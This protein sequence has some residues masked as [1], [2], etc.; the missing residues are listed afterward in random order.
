MSISTPLPDTFP[1]PDKRFGNTQDDDAAVFES[2]TEDKAE[3]PL[4][5][6]LPLT[7]KSIP[8]VSPKIATR[9]MTA[10]IS[11]DHSWPPYL[12]LPKDTNRTTIQIWAAS[13]TPTDYVR[14]S[15]DAGK[16]QSK[17]GSALLYSGQAIEFNSAHSGPLWVSCPDANGPVTVSVIAVTS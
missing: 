12:L 15:D 10:S 16:L 9:L 4:P 2:Y 14:I 6:E 5:D 17:F 11:L 7:N 1:N 13:D 8:L 3:P